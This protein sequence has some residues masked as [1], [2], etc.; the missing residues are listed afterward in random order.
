ML[1]SA[2]A[3]HALPLLLAGAGFV[4]LAAALRRR[5]WQRLRRPRD[6]LRFGGVRPRRSSRTLA[7]L[8]PPAGELDDYE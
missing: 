3:P 1:L 2:S 6:P 4:L 8:L 7:E 5:R